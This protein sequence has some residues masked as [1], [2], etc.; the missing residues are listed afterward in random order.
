M[1]AASVA[2]VAAVNPNGI[3]RFLANGFSL[4]FMKDNPDFSNT[5]KSLSKNPSYCPISC[6]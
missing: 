3:K 4:F 2:D 5:P 6:N 1:K